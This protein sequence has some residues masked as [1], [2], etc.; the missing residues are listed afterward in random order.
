MV[1]ISYKI[2]GISQQVTVSWLVKQFY[3]FLAPT[4]ITKFTES[5]TG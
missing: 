3:H 2:H 1:M 4:L 5:V